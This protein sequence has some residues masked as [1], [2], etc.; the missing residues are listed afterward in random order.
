LPLK[1]RQNTT[2]TIRSPS[3]ITVE[4]ESATDGLVP[5]IVHVEDPDGDSLTV[6]WSIDG[7]LARTETITGNGSFTS[8]DVTLP[9]SYGLGTHYITAS[10]TDADDDTAVSG[11][12]VTVADTTP[13]T[14]TSLTATPDVLAP[15]THWLTPV[16]LSVSATDNCGP[17][18]CRIISVTSTE[19]IT[20][21]PNGR[22]EPDWL[23]TG[24]LSLY[25]R[26]ERKSNKAP[27][28]YTINV[29]CKDAS[30]NVSMDTIDVTVPR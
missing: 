28:I 1:P 5:L 21:R 26:A 25:L 29:E 14:I 11:T 2:P 12:E 27:R 8:A 19:P 16:Q 20:P 17:A 6:E 3:Q 24:D 15:L 7:S 18:S 30:G 22:I 10:V 23:I 13:P 9:A 4:C